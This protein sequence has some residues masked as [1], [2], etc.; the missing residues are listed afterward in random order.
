MT[1][2]LLAASALAGLKAYT[3]GHS[4]EVDSV[5]VSDVQLG[6]EVEKSDDGEP[7]DSAGS[8]FNAATE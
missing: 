8:A 2:A 6:W 5:I 4:S 1:M 7:A 3:T